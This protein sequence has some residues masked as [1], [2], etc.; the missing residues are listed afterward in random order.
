MHSGAF[1]CLHFGAHL[2]QKKMMQKS[3]VG[4]KFSSDDVSLS[5]SSW[6]FWE[7]MEEALLLTLYF[8]V[9]S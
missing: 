2:G 9:I 4:E 5:C 7:L 1:Q 8:L 3:C 6:I